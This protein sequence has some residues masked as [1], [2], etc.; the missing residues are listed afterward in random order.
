M[1]LACSRQQTKDDYHVVVTSAAV[2][3]LSSWE[4]E[5]LSARHVT[6]R[7]VVPAAARP[8][9]PSAARPHLRH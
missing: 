7:A 8:L 4:L 1:M 9:F 2:F 6:A 5:N 3:C